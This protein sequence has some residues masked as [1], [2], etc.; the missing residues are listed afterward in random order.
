MWISEAKGSPERQKKK[1]NVEQ[2][3]RKF[4]DMSSADGNQ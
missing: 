1:E 4:N 2:I 3:N